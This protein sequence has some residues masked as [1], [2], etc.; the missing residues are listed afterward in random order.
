MAVRPQVFAAGYRFN[1][2]VGPQAGQYIMGSEV[3]FTCRLERDWII[4]RAYRLGRHMYHQER[5]DG[6]DRAPQL[7]GSPHWK[8]RNLLEQY[9]RAAT[10]WLKRDFDTQFCAAWEISFLHGYLAEG[11]QTSRTG[12]SG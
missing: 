2:R 7:F 9:L 10:G 5:T 1:E 12:R 8:Y 6:A 4:Q 11:R 3:E